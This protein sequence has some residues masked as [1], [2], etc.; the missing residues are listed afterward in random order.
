MLNAESKPQTISKETYVEKLCNQL[1]MQRHRVMETTRLLDEI[2]DRLEGSR[3]ETVEQE[4]D[5]KTA[6]TGM[7]EHVDYKMQLL[8]YSV[9]VLEAAVNRLEEVN[10]V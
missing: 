7:L 8:S 6:V 1:D 10:I 3:P 9:G 2:L 5:K 4:D